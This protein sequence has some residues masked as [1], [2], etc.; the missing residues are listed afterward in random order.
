MKFTRIFPLTIVAVALY[1]GACKKEHERKGCFY[2]VTNDSMYSN[3]P[4]LNNP[5]FKKIGNLDTSDRCQFTKSMIDNWVKQNT[6]VDT[7]YHSHDTLM[8]E[9]HTMMCNPD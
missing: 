9:Y 2:C 7:Y 5:H 6:F 4:T 1:F 8:L 3:I